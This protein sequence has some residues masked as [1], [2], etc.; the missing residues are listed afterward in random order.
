[1]QDKTKQDKHTNPGMVAHACK[2]ILLEM[3]VKGSL[4]RGKLKVLPKY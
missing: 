3:E 4:P 1:M 2:S